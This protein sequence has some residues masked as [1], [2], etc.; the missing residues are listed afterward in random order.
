MSSRNLCIGSRRPTPEPLLCRRPMGSPCM[1]RRSAAAR[2]ERKS[3]LGSGSMARLRRM[4]FVCIVLLFALFAMRLYPK[5][6]LDRRQTRTPAG[7]LRQ[8]GRALELELMYSERE[9][10]ETYLNLVPC[11]GNIEAAGAASLIYFEQ[12]ARALTLAE[13]LT[14]AVIPQSPTQR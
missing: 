5:R 13:T 4:R 10:L 2:W 6:R 14:L 3:R 1:N 12:P 9:I 8:V 11:G 7:K